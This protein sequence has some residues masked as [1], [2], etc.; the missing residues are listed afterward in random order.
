MASFIALKRSYLMVKTKLVYVLIRPWMDSKF[1]R[2]QIRSCEFS[3]RGG[4]LWRIRIKEKATHTT[5]ITDH[6]L[7][8]FSSKH[9]RVKSTVYSTVD[10]PSRKWCYKFCFLPRHLQR[11]LNRQQIT[12][13]SCFIMTSLFR[14]GSVPVLQGWALTLVR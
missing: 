8:L 2:R 14:P 7:F 3:T 6:Y 9:Q 13:P 4:I 5:K 12:A 11:I 1:G 10:L